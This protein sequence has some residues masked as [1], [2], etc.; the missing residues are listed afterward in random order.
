MVDTNSNGSESLPSYKTNPTDA[1]PSYRSTPWSG[2]RTGIYESN[3]EASTSPDNGQLPEKDKLACK[4]NSLSS[5]PANAN[6][7]S[8]APCNAGGLRR[9]P[10]SWDLSLIRSNGPVNSISSCL[11]EGTRENNTPLP[12]SYS[13]S[14]LEKKIKNFLIQL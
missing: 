9:S 10:A 14:Y 13:D 7:S 6:S 11:A 3:L 4:S 12:N 1:P 8:S 5:A 2:Y